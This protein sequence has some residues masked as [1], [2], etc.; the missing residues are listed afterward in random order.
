MDRLQALLKRFTVS[1]ETFHTGPLCG[2]HDF[3]GNGEVGQLHLIR[4]GRVEIHHASGPAECVD[5][6]SLV[7]YP[8]PLPHRFVTDAHAGAAMACANLRYDAGPANPIARALPAVVV[9]PLADVG[10]ADLALELLFA[11]AFGNRCGRQH[12]LDRLF[13]VV[14]VFVLRALM[15]AGRI[16]SGLFA[17]MGHASLARALVAVHEAPATPWTLETLAA[18]AAMSRSHFAAKFRELV[19][20]TPGDYLA[21]FRVSL[22]QEAMRRGQPLKT[23]AQSVGYGSPAALSRAFTAVS[24]MSP[25]AWKATQVSGSL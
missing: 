19:G 4:T 8:R 9:M 24:G 2:V 16:E 1:A 10:G 12:V 23:I 5:V 7:F 17:A 22:A 21:S 18:Q 20:T 3:P 15:D 13:E 14:L 11:E 6:P 25:R